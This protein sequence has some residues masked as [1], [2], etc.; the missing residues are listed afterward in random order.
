MS[1]VSSLTLDPLWCCDPPPY[2]FRTLRLSDAPTYRSLR[3]FGHLLFG[4]NPARYITDIHGIAPRPW[5]GAQ[6]S[7]AFDVYLAI[8][9][10]VDRRVQVAL[11]RDTPDWRLKNACP[12][13]LYKVEGEPHLKFA[14]IGT[15]DGNNS[16]SRFFLREREESLAD[17]TSAPGASREL[18]DNRVVPGDYY[19]PRDEVD[20]W[21]KEGVADVMKSFDAEAEEEEEDDSGCADRWQN[22][23][24]EVTARLYGM[25]DETGFFPALCRHGFVLKVVDMVSGEL[26][27]YPL[28]LTA[29]ILNILGEVALAYD[30]GC[31]YKKLVKAHPLLKELAADKNFRALVGAFH[32]YGHGCLCGLENFMTYVEGVG[33]EAG[34]GCEIF[35]SKSNALAS[36]TRYASWFHRQ[37]A[38][39]TYLKHVDTFETYH[40]LSSLLCSKY[41]HALEVKAT[42]STLRTAMQEL[43]VESRDVFETW[44][45][46]EKA[47]LLT[48]SKEPSEET[49]EMEYYQ[50]LVNLMDVEERV[51]AMRGVQVPFIPTEADDGYAEAA[52]ATRRIETQRRHALELQ[53]RAL[54]AVQELEVRLTVETRWTPDGEKW[55]TASKMMAKRQYQRVLDHL[56]GLIIARMFELAKCNMSGTGYKLR[57]HISKS[58]QVRSKAVKAAIARYNEVAEAMTPPKPTLD[59]EDVVEYAFLADFDLLREGRED[60]RGE[61]W[62]QPAGRA[63]MDQ[64]YKLLRADEEIVRLNVEIRRFVTYMVDEEAFL[65]REEG[66]LLEEGMAELASQVRR[67]RMER[68]RF[69]TVHMTRLVKLSKVPGFTGNILAGTSLCR[70]RHTP[71]ARDRDVE[72]R[73][74]SP[75]HPLEDVGV[76]PVADGDEE[77]GDESED[78]DGTLADAFMNIL[79]MSGD[80]AADTEER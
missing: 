21:S 54:T 43:G 13:C 50:K 17:G 75:S 9:A 72:M 59:W 79:R 47:H 5:L 51:A 65:I 70:D 28:S 37:Q 25:Y 36:T 32:G 49:L 26:S 38:I 14:F 19:L 23:K 4:S 63:A 34:E 30:I 52:K 48:L 80:N 2:T 33:L 74:P 42:Y 68:A 44:R 11:G 39:T 60:I 41:R 64:H 16:L 10:R 35:F 46:K 78:E 76:A 73:P 40:G 56:Q 61:P 77:E 6:F 20:K 29:H 7:V 62:A 45:A 67:A 24:E 53:A 27:K 22:M 12:A 15:I 57:K 55:A 66:R 18:R 58:L 3:S 31:K 69:T 8:L 71:V 1:F